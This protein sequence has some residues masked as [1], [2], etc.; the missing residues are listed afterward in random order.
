[1]AKLPISA[2]LLHFHEH[3]RFFR[4]CGYPHIP[5]HYVDFSMRFHADMRI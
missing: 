4:I 1:M 2:G 5:I 3:M